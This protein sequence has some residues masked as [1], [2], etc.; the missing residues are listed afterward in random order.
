GE[1]VV[2][3][4]GRGMRCACEI[5][6]ADAGKCEVQVKNREMIRERNHRIHIAIAPPKKISR[7]EWFLEKATETGIDEIT[8]ILCVHSERK[9]IN[10]GR[11][12]KILVSSMKQSQRATLPHL[13]EMIKMDQFASKE[14]EE[15]RFI[16]LCHGEWAGSLPHLQK[17]VSGGK[18][19]LVIIGPEG[20]FSA[21]E[22]QCSVNRGYQPASL[23]NFRL[24]TETAGLLA[25]QI[26]NLQQQG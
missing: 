1:Q 16:A 26:L 9:N 25:C 10:P 5:I 21:D 23:G 7:L 6:T 14:T 24:R 19:A 22:I 18:D 2:V 15:E 17:L 3:V 4:N 20:G 11:M 8:P 12:H 13:N